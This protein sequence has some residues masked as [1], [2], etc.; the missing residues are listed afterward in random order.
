MRLLRQRILHAHVLEHKCPLIYLLA[1]DLGR[2]AARAV[3]SLGFDADEHRGRALLVGLQARGEF[4]GVRWHHA[5]VVV[6]GGY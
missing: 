3:A 6:G 2:R 1:N 5:V 4:E